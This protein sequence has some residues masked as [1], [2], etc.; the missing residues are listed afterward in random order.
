MEHRPGP[1]G[2]LPARYPRGDLSA[3]I[4]WPFKYIEGPHVAAALFDLEQDPG[5]Q[6]NLAAQEPE[7][8]RAMSLLLRQLA[9]PGSA[10]STARDPAAEE[11][12]RALGYVR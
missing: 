10:Q 1:Q 5:E 6:R 7:Q 9:G 12:L 3:L 11:R 2:D 4:L 8:A